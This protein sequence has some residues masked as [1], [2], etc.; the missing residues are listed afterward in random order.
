MSQEYH[1]ETERYYSWIERHDTTDYGADRDVGFL[2]LVGAVGGMILLKWVRR[3]RVVFT[4]LAV[5]M[6]LTFV[7]CLEEYGALDAASYSPGITTGS[8]PGIGL[9]LATVASFLALAGAAHGAGAAWRGTR[10]G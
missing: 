5:T 7:G 3:P 10:E 4:F 6:F 8:T 2:A 9:L 1:P